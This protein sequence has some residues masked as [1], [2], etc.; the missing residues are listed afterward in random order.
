MAH[1]SLMSR[2]N[3]A[4]ICRSKKLESVKSGP[5]CSCILDKSF[6][7][8]ISKA[9]TIPE[10]QPLFLFANQVA[11]PCLNQNAS[12]TADMVSKSLSLYLIT[13]L[14]YAVSIDCP[15]VINLAT[16]LAMGLSNPDLLKTLRI[17]CCSTNSVWCISG[18]VDSINW[19]GMKLT[20][21]INTTALP[22]MLTYLN[23]EGNRIAGELR[24][25]LPSAL[26]VLYIGINCIT[27]SIPVMPLPN[28]QE[29][30]ASQNRFNGTIPSL[31]TTLGF[32]SISFNEISG[33]IPG[34]LPPGMYMMKASNNM[35]SC[36]IPATLPNS[37]GYLDASSNKISGSIP[38]TLP[39]SM[40]A[41]DIGWN[42]IS[43]V[44]PSLS[45]NIFSLGL[46][47]LAVSGSIHLYQPSYVAI[48]KTSISSV[49]F[50]DNSRLWH[51]NMRDTALSNPANDPQ[52][53]FCDRSATVPSTK[54]DCN[55]V[56]NLAYGMNLHILNPDLMQE[57]NSNCCLTT[58]RAITCDASNVIEISWNYMSLNGTINGTA[59]PSSIQKLELS[60]N[61]IFGEIPTSLPNSFKYLDLSCNS[62]SGRIP[63]ILPPNLENLYLSNNLLNGSVPTTLPMNL[64]KL[65]LE[66]NYLA[67][68]LPSFLPLTLS[69]ISLYNNH[70]SGSL[71]AFP[72]ALNYLFLNIGPAFNR[73][74]GELT[75]NKP[76]IIY[77]SHNYITNLTIKDTS[78][79][80]WCDISSNPLIAHK[81]DADL[82]KCTKNNLYIVD[83]VGVIALAE[84]LNLDVVQ[85]DLMASIETNCCSSAGVTCTAGKVDRIE[86]PNMNLNGTIDASHIPSNLT[87]L[88]LSQNSITGSV[89]QGM[90]SSLVNLTLNS[91]KLSGAIP[92]DLA[93]SLEHLYLSDNMID[94]SIPTVLPA[95]LLSLLLNKNKLSG[96]L[97]SS[98][99]SGLVSLDVS[100]NNLSGPVPDLS[101]VEYIYLNRDAPPYNQ[102]TGGISVRKPKELYVPNNLITNILIND[103]QQMMIC[104]ISNNPLLVN[105]NDASLSSCVK[106]GAGVQSTSY[107]TTTADITSS[108][109]AASPVSDTLTSSDTLD[110]ST[111]SDYKET[112]QSVSMTSLATLS[113][114]KTST[115]AASTEA[116]STEAVSVVDESLEHILRSRSLR[117]RSKQQ[118]ATVTTLYSAAEPDA[119]YSN[120][121]QPVITNYNTG[122]LNIN[123][124]WS[125]FIIGRCVLSVMVAIAVLHYTPFTRSIKGWRLS[126]AKNSKNTKE[127]QDKAFGSV[128]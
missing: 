85:P 125:Y 35:L 10:H 70:L 62:L 46:Q 11:R 104:N 15:D 22:G 56:V 18:R 98:I 30:D 1:S 16:G 80:T 23:L 17:D 90:P 109:Y 75:L 116:V 71:P 87:A 127:S 31:S 119:T 7:L 73:F 123:I 63:A 79:L 34:T 47:S 60:C 120:A 86:W 45:S 74:E 55:N 3:S 93:L 107:F 12:N 69:E 68:Q 97:P 2:K 102:F 89:P 113:K 83:C 50:D 76:K 99:P 57:I 118:S 110:I 24:G 41:I 51:C 88:D 53:A 81:D 67:G 95:G 8:E 37:L 61:F 26:E 43:G 105:V 96:S 101:N 32:F 6:I 19:F 91:N 40:Y 42:Q 111:T 9:G 25:D 114:L 126:Q 59:I 108:V 72:D 64:I 66:T 39:S 49:I 106:Y 117:T 78:V 54:P 112:L 33:C 28:L 20:G 4:Y 115:T 100:N 92:S 121:L 27:G 124:R 5:Y 36:S 65:Y 14:F 77:I 82:T 29:I 38:A 44:V 94:G 21:S 128:F 122:K 48:G 52:L 103:T 84:G 13:A 58:T